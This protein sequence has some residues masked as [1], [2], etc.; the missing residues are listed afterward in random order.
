[1]KEGEGPDLLKDLLSAGVITQEEYDTLVAKREASRPAALETEQ[2]ST[3]DQN[4]DTN[5]DA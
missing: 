3:A 1:M 2:G 5:G 4:S